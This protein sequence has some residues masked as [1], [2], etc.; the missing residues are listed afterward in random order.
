MSKGDG[1]SVDVGFGHVEFQLFG[2]GEELCCE[3]F[4]YF[5][6]VDVGEG[7]VGDCE[8]VLDG[9]DGANS[10]LGGFAAGGVPGGELAEGFK[11]VLFYGGL[12]GED[13]GAGSVADSGGS[14]G[15]DDALLVEDGAEL[16]DLLHGGGR[17][18]V[19]VGVDGDHALP[20]L[21]LDGGDLGV[22]VTSLLGLSPGLLGAD[23]EL[24]ALLAGDVVLLGEVLGGDSHGSSGIAVGEA[25]PETIRHLQRV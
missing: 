10:H 6:A 21:D 1:T 3:G 12:A 13:D 19:L 22:E 16:A 17:L 8:G 5:Y 18:G 4:V 20:G 9:G 25:G 15:G 2:A 11:V 14:G 23:G 7:L 24:V